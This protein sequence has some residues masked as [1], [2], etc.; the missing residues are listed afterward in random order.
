M[1]SRFIMISRFRTI[2]GRE[3]ELISMLPQ[4][5]DR[6][7]LK[8]V[9]NPEV[10]EIRALKDSLTL[11]NL[12]TEAPQVDN[13]QIAGLLVADVRREILDFVEAPKDC[14]DL[15]PRTRYIQLRHVEV[16]PSM[17]SAYRAWRDETI[18]EVVR[19]HDP[20]AVFLAYHSL[21]SGVPGVMFLAGF[22]TDIAT[23]TTAFT[24]DRYREIVQQ[25]GDTYIT[26]GTEGLYT[27]VYEGEM[28]ETA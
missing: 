2:P 5:P 22:D 28:A 1:S 15:L 7:L 8:S 14:A 9:E 4:G 16:K 12:V 17:M 19:A 27:E 18:F 11:I 25:A 20:A 26:G 24:D 23:Y 21:I 10:I 13:S 6:R 3:Q